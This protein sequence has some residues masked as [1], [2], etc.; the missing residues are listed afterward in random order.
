MFQA[1]VQLTPAAGPAQLNSEARLSRGQERSYVSARAGEG[2]SDL[3]AQRTQTP[4]K[5]R[6]HAAISPRKM[7]P[8]ALH[9]PMI[10]S[11]G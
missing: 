3:S 1:E 5:C 11:F 4:C 6:H 8:S 9:E 10:G 7:L 2:A